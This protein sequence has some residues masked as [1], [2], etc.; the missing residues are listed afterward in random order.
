MVSLEWTDWAAA[1]TTSGMALHV[2]YMALLGA[3]TDLRSLRA[4]SLPLK[5]D[6]AGY[7]LVAVIVFAG[8]M[9]LSLAL[10]Y[11]SVMVVLR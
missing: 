1:V 2:A 6:L 10:A 8:T 4:S 3:A 11:A 7:A 9:A 5:A